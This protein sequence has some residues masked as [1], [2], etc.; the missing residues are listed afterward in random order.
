MSPHLP[1]ADPLPTGAA[2]ATPP[3]P[4]PVMVVAIAAS[5]AA[6]VTATIVSRIWHF[7]SGEGR[8]IISNNNNACQDIFCIALS[9]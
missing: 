7:A 8:A 3:G 6:G 1:G 2:V 4:A 9:N 5:A